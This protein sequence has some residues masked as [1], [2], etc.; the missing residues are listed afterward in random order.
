MDPY[1]G[2]HLGDF[3]RRILVVV[4]FAAL[5]LGLWQLADLLVLL[6]GAVLIA[7][8][9][10][11]AMQWATRLTGIGDMAALAAVVLLFVGALSLALWFFGTVVAGQLDE[12]V[13]QVPAGLRM[14]AE[15]L[16]A[17]PYGRYAIEHARG[18]D[19]LGVTGWAAS[20]LATV[21][22]GLTR[23]IG[24]AVLT[25]ILAI[26]LAAQ[27]DRY[28]R[29]CMRLVPSGYRTRLERLFDEAARI[30]RRWL[31]GQLVV[32]V[33]IGIL[34]G[35]GLWALGVEAAFALGL[36]GGLL[37]FIPYVGAVLAAIPATLVALTQGPGEALSVVVMYVGVH[38]VEGN[39]ITPMVQ[40]EASALPPVL[41]LLST[42]GFSIL[43]GPSAVL[44]AAPLTLFLMIAVD[45]LY[46]EQTLGEP[47]AICADAAT[48]RELPPE[49]SA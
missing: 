25:F 41:A 1:G 47:G 14:A 29:I 36:I 8:G 26:Y 4:L 3:T 9:L 15:R 12:L 23:G 45:V 24:Y 21:A 32:M 17:H 30:L 16:Q 7:I 5:A 31:L 20:A 38:F 37:C 33:T 19:T 44:L 48:A 2:P 10:L 34:S 46:I 49:H 11:A 6:F 18:V 28:R 27:P 42:V 43:I 35:M 40:A 39:F 22:R 13:R